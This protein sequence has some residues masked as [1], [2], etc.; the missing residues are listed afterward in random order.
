MTSRPAGPPLQPGVS[1]IACTNRPAFLQNLI[2]NYKRQLYPRKELLIV[3]NS[4]RISPSAYREAT[5]QLKNVRVYAMP[6]NRSLGACL[7]F[8]VGKARY[9]VAAKFDD[10][11]YYAPYYLTESLL[12]MIRTKADVVG[13]RTH[14]MYLNGSKALILRFSGEQNRSVSV[15]PGATLVFRRS[16]FSKVR[17]PNQS[18]GEDD[19]FCLRC[20]QKGFKVYSGSPHN[21]VAIRRKNSSGHTWIISDRELLAHNRIVPH[22]RDYKSHV[23]RK[24]FR[25]PQ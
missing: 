21:F 25:E 13:K 19:Q 8:A 22:V 18:V 10:D 1:V 14:Y 6:Q 12:T 20:K 16:V 3:V 9:P 5:R 15:L 2:Q 11:D 7:N 17:F 23:G 24:P 4:D